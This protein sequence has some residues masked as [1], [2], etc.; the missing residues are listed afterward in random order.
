[1]EK[2]QQFEQRESVNSIKFFILN[3]SNSK[4]KSETK[5][6]V[7][8]LFLKTRSDTQLHQ[9]N[10]WK[11][12]YRNKEQVSEDESNVNT[13]ENSRKRLLEDKVEM[14]TIRNNVKSFI[15]QIERQSINNR[16]LVFKDPEDGKHSSKK[17]ESMYLINILNI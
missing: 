12:E 11:P 15:E 13:I 5:E 6:T 10:A 8:D 4:T 7:K 14:A 1:M 17:A 2:T 3:K 16:A 9:N